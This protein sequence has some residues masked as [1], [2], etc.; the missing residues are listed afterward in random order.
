VSF[1]V[2]PIAALMLI[3]G[4]SLTAFGLGSGRGFGVHQIVPGAAGF[5]LVSALWG[6]ILGAVLGLIGGLFRKARQEGG[7]AR[8]W[9]AVNQPVGLFVRRGRDQSS[10]R[11][12]RRPGFFRRNWPWLVGVPELLAL[13]GGF[14]TGAYF[15]KVVDRRL[16]EATGAADRDDPNWRIDDLL[17]HRESI[18]DEENSALVV[19]AALEGLPENWP[20]GRRIVP[21]QPAPPASPV[22]KALDRLHATPDNARLDDQTAEVLRNELELY[23]ESVQLA[24]SVADHARGQHELELGPTLYD[25]SLAETQ[26]ARSLARLLE[27]DAAIRAHDGNAD[28]ALDSCRAIL[29]VGRSIGDE[30]FAISMLVRVAIG[31]TATKS[32]RRVLAQG[33]PSDESL[34]QMQGL[35]IDELSQPLELLAMRG[36]RAMLVEVIR[37]VAAGELSI[38]ELS[39]SRPNPNPAGLRYAIAPWGK[40]MFDNQQ[41]VG[42]ELMNEA[43]AIA[44]QPVAA[45]APL[46]KAWGAEL[47]RLRRTPF[48]AYTSVI[49][50]L[51]MP[52]LSSASDALTRYAG[53]LG[54]TAILIATERHRRK[55]GAW[56]PA[57]EAIDASI[58]SSAPNDPYAG[59]PYR[60]KREEDRILVYSVGPNGSDED[61]EYDPKQW[62][63]GVADD[64][65]GSL[66]EAPSRRR[67]FSPRSDQAHGPTSRP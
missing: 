5:Y 53:E 49:P 48:F 21:G 38:S 10:T 26:A 50:M 66:W 61:G 17:A 42:L 44:R 47:N 29:G 32:T 33:E 20:A 24:R 45:R 64:V 22:V 6:G 59:R 14:G 16:T 35:L 28:G 40:L 13:A 39:Q 15:G 43:V 34:R 11:G 23:D 12:G 67:L 18:P 7:I 30:P 31:V 55:S 3:P 9:K 62:G 36:E 57:I 1:F 41:A 25:T 51:M 54:S 60:M 27:A 46:W 56:P 2:G 65:G 37:R 63:K 4:L 58:L 8:W 19:T 52:A